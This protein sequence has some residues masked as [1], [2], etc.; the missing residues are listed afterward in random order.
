[1]S[2]TSILIVEDEAL[3][4]KTL[5]RKLKR[6]GYTVNAIVSSSDSAIQ[7]VNQHQPDLI[8]MDIAIKG[9][10]DGIETATIIQEDFHIP[11]VYLTA[12]ADEGTIERA[13]QTTCYGYL[14]KPF[15]EKELH[16]TL[17]MAMSQHRRMES[18]RQEA[19]VPEVEDSQ[20]VY[21]DPL[22]GFPNQLVLRDHFQKLI[23]Q[24][25]EA[26]QGDNTIALVCLN[27]DRFKRINESVGDVDVALLIKDVL[28]RLD[29]STSPHDAFIVRC[30]NQDEFLLM[31]LF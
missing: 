12:Y 9:D 17:T 1:M 23:A 20:D 29:S 21:S 6:L 5:A 24:M 4:A 16:A 3:I 19:K 28:K 30:N 2:A 7:E 11:V 26:P 18:T 27:L 15:K 10:K 8:L 14:L 31:F 13:S 22:T 25:P